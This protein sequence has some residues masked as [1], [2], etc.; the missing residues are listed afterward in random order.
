MES[1]I[2]MNSI[3][4][5]HA[6]RHE[7][8]HAVFADEGLILIGRQLPRQRHNDTPRQLCIPLLFG[9]FDRIPERLTVGIFPWRVGWQ[10]DALR[11][12]FFFLVTEI[13]RP[14]IVLAEQLFS[15][16]IGSTR[17]GGLPLAALADGYIKVGTCHARQ[18]TFLG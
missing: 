12:D 7:L 16:H 6:P 18:P 11:H 9:R 2:I 15:R 10:Q 14:L 5:D 3:V 8:L 13:L 1:V 4:G 17:Y